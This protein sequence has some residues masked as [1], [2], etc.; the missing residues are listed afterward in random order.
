[1]TQQPASSKAD[2]LAA[3]LRTALATLRLHR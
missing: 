3:P 2:I 1:M